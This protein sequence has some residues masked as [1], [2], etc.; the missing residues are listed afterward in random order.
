LGRFWAFLGEG[1]SKTSFCFLQKVHVENIFQRNT[2][3]FRCQFASIFVVAFSGVSQRWEF[4]KTTNKKLQKNRVEKFLQ[5]NRQK[6][7]DLI[8]RFCLSRFWAFFGEGVTGVQNQH[9]KTS[10]K[11]SDPGLFSASDLPTEV[12]DFVFC[13]TLR[14]TALRTL[15]VQA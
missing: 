2:Q 9:K 15:R 5:K 7:T 11:T 8:S 1:S 14:K 12:P 10:G 4:Q 6:K 3:E 13:G